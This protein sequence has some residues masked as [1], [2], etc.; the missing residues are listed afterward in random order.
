M[1]LFGMGRKNV[2]NE[3]SDGALMV[4]IEALLDTVDAA[5]D[6]DRELASDIAIAELSGTKLTERYRKLA[7]LIHRSWSLTKKVVEWFR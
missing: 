2:K 7:I 6:V 1:N 5:K 3:I 4:K